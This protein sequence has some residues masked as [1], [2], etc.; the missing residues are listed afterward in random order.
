MPEA[1]LPNSSE[2]DTDFE[3]VWNESTC[4]SQNKLDLVKDLNLCKQK[5][6]HQGWKKTTKATYFSEQDSI[7]S[8]VDIK[9]FLIKSS[10]KQYGP[11]NNNNKVII[12]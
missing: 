3:D 2:N 6:W 10:L 12:L 7:A 4:F 1:L 9:N 5:C 8:W 11:T